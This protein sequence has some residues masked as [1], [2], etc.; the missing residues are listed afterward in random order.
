MPTGQWQRERAAP[1]GHSATHERPRKIAR[2]ESCDENSTNEDDTVSLTATNNLE[3]DI[4]E[5]VNTP[6]TPSAEA[7]DTDKFLEDVASILDSSEAT[8]KNLQPK[9]HVADIANKRWGRKMAPDKLKE[10]I[11]KHLHGNDN[12]SC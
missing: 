9:L 3:N 6:P 11:S 8:G 1:V 12:S 4:A 10:L 2:T 5:L 7:S